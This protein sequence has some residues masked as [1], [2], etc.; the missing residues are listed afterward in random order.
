MVRRL[1]R[2]GDAPLGVLHV[3]SIPFAD[4]AEQMTADRLRRLARPGLKMREDPPLEDALAR[5]QQRYDRLAL[6]VN[7]NDEWTGILTF[8][9]VLQEI[10][11]TM[12]TNSNW[13]ARANSS[14]W[15]MPS[16]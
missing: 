10:V 13:H 8:E 7:D 6:V 11:G 3:K 2:L 12:G 9:D 5:F 1:G 14:R 4:P 15:T 16:V